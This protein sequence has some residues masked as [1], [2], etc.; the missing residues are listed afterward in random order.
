LQR[1][2]LDEWTNPFTSV[3]ASIRGRFAAIVDLLSERKAA[4]GLESEI[5]ATWRLQVCR[6]W[7][8]R[9]DIVGRGRSGN[10]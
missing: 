10:D 7:I 4:F 6:R 5:A 1:S 8:E 9:G 3:V 2:K